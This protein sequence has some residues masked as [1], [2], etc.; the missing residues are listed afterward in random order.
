MHN[1]AIPQFH[2]S[3]IPKGDF[4]TRSNA[5]ETAY[6]RVNPND[7]DGDGL[8]NDIDVNPT[9]NDGDFFGTGVNWLNVNCEG[10]LSAATNGMGEV[11]IAW[12]TN[13]NPNAY[14]WLELA[15]TGALGVAKITA[16]CD[17]E[18]YLGDLAIIARTN[19]VCHI[20][21]LIGAAYTVES[22][23]PIAY[24]SVSSEHASI[25]TN[26]ANQLTVSYPVLFAFEEVNFRSNPPGG[27]RTYR[28]TTTPS[29]LCASVLALSGGCCSASINEFGVSMVCS[30]NCLCVG[31]AHDMDVTALWE[32]YQGHGVADIHCACANEA[33]DENGAFLAM[34]FSSNLV[35]FE[36]S[37]ANDPGIYVP[38]RSTDVFLAGRVVGGRYGGRLTYSMSN[39]NKLMLAQGT[40]F[41]SVEPMDISPGETEEV[42]ARFEGLAA[43]EGVGDI[44]AGATFVENMTGRVFSSTTSVT[45]VK[46]EL[47]PQVQIQGAQNRHRVG[48]GEYVICLT[49]PQSMSCEILATKNGTVVEGFGNRKFKSPFCA[50]SKGLCFAFT[51]GLN[52]EPE[53]DVI[54]PS[55]FV[56][57]R[58]MEI[59]YSN[60]VP[61]MAG[62]CGMS[63]ELS[64]APTNVSFQALDVMEV[65][66]TDEVGIAPTGF[67]LDERFSNEWHHTTFCGAGNWFDVET[68]NHFATDKAE[69]SDGHAAPWSSGSIT[70]RIPMA[71]RPSG[72]TTWPNGHVVFGE[73]YFQTFT[74]DAAGTVRVDKLSHWVERS[75]D[76]T[77]RKSPN[78]E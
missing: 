69:F 64:L 73:P 52:Y 36:D 35:V 62:W 71:W 33:Q 43:S 57:T 55:H 59:V 46:V 22:D 18:S 16:T 29:E 19:E 5:L 40:V 14:Y 67:F 60:A 30:N 45:S 8:A 28:L 39:G 31:C 10:V 23:L 34:R 44:V 17:G 48:I 68:G 21:L 61:N 72:D 4:S 70:W 47:F 6:R 50:E 32:G 66:E 25:F 24:S 2:N 75:P 11:A 9:V 54:E 15:A 41:P 49:Y 74:I 20:P 26:S 3:T 12:H 37:Y 1:S 63:L 58:A 77:R 13:A 56:V 51:N 42:V 76:G 7:W 78:T 65:P 38:R 53:L 27:S